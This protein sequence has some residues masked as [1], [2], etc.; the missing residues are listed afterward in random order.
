MFKVNY[1]NQGFYSS[2]TRTLISLKLNSILEIKLLLLEVFHKESWED[3][4]FIVVNE[5]PIVYIK[6]L[7]YEKPIWWEEFFRGQAY[8]IFVFS[9]LLSTRLHKIFLALF[10]YSSFQ[11]LSISFFYHHLACT[12][13]VIFMDAIIIVTTLCLTAFWC[14]V[15]FV[16]IMLIDKIIYQIPRL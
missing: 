8:H 5:K 15:L 13:P 14:L 9:Y 4:S 16:S 10:S 6:P 12:S 11:E 7:V 1:K 3:V 2:S